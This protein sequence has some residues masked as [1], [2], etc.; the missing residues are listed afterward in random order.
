MATNIE[1]TLKRHNG[2]DYD[3]LFPTTSWAQVYDHPST[4]TPT[5]HTHGNITNAGA[6]GS[7]SGLPIITTT[8]GALTTGAFGTSSGQFAQGNDDRFC[9]AEKLTSNATSTSTSYAATNLAIDLATNSTYRVTFHGKWTTDAATTGLK[10][11]I[12]YSGTGDAHG[13]MEASIVQTTAATELTQS[14]YTVS[15][16][17]TTGNSMT[18]TGGTL[19]GAMFSHCEFII[20]TTSSG[21]VTVRI[22]SEVSASQ[23][24][25]LAG[26]TLMVQRITTTSV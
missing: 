19:A 21:T 26:A 6:I 2:T 11:G 17:A 9:V 16:S 14:F 5:S 18:L 10:Y 20:H 23:V 1:I 4:F 25:L 24:D 7:T 3:P 8:S 12:T 15:A 22:A 13:Y